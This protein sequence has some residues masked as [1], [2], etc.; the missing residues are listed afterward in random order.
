MLRQ[1]R[2]AGSDA[3]LLHAVIPEAALRLQ[4]GGPSVLAAQLEWL[5][6]SAG[7]QN[8]TIQALPS[9]A[10]AHPAL[11][12]NF[13][14]LHFADSKSDPPLGYFD[15]P[16]GGYLISDDGEVA[17]M[18]NMFDDVR[19]IALDEAESVEMITAVLKEIS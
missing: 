2:I 3:L 8:V 7:A 16:I 18:I 1:A 13:S 5:L 9:S 17:D 11:A 15:G 12:S 4:I 6:I 19:S 10:G 14:V